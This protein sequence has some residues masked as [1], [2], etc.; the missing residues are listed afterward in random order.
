MR[1]F[2]ALVNKD[3]RLFF[4]DGRAVL[5]SVIA[6]IVIA[7]FF[8][9]IFGGDTRDRSASRVSIYVVDE[10]G[11]TVSKD[12]AARLAA[13]PA[14]A[15]KVGPLSEARGA[16]RRGKAA[17][18]IQFPRGFGQSAADAFFG[19]GGRPKADLPLFYDPSHA[20]EA[21][22]VQ[23]I[24]AGHAMEAVS[25]EMFS[26]QAGREAVDQSLARLEQDDGLPAE[27]RGALTTML[28]GVRGWNDLSQS[29]K[30]SG[31]TTGGLTVPFEVKKQAVTSG[32]G[33]PYNGYAHSF[34][35]M[36]VQFILFMAIDMGV[37]LLLQRRDGL[38]KRLRAAPLSR[39]V[40]LGSR[41]TSTAILSLFILATLF[42][43]ARVVFGVRLE[44]SVLGFVGICLAFSLMTA[45]FGL[46]IA[47]L[48]KTPE[49]TRGLAIVATL[50]LVMLGGAWVPTFV[51]PG[52]LQ[53][54]TAVVPTRWAIDGLD[55]TTWRGL[56]LAAVSWP[57]LFLLAAALTFGALAVAR[58]RWEAD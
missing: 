5:M 56:G 25:K 38:W 29:G 11:S 18:A 21:S 6:P 53:K 3:L 48:G 7:S 4:S 55:A 19:G 31:G 50:M 15:V 14:L 35:G 20:T 32:S 37:G 41:A 2:A 44:G 17:V 13:D 24:L 40:L 43:F 45:A 52:W 30:T 9:F 58:F 33:T 36:G 23:G 22:M 34:A 57:I 42:L 51:F 10:D 28:R 46:L 26:G 39:T 8:G 12:L 16:V 1:P 54:A 47:S 49:S 27:E